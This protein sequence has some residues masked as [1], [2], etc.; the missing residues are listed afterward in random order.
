MPVL[1]FFNFF[2]SQPSKINKVKLGG[3]SAAQ[4]SLVTPRSGDVWAGG[5]G[6]TSPS[7][8][9]CGQWS[10]C[11]A[12][13]QAG[14]LQPGPTAQTSPRHSFSAR[15]RHEEG[16]GLGTQ[17][18]ARCVGRGMLRALVATVGRVL[19]RCWRSCPGTFTSGRGCESRTCCVCTRV[20]ETLPSMEPWGLLRRRMDMV[21]RR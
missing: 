16:S 7:G 4:P 12:Q 8:L 15:V 6:G 14:E 20:M 17:R 18:R 5:A 21:K 1:G 10:C 19:G 9:R 11:S 3:T 13:Q 2:L